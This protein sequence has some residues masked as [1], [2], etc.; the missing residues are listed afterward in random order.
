MV[1]YNFKLEENKNLPGH[2]FHPEKIPGDV[3]NGYVSQMHPSVLK[4]FQ[5]SH[6]RRAKVNHHVS[7]F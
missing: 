4:I 5:R 7:I 1:L 6:E 3:M 2:K